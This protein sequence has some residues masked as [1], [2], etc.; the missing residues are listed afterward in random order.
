MTGDI[1]AAADAADSVGPTTTDGCSA[2]TN[3]SAVAGKWALVDRGPL[4]GN[5]TFVLKAQ[6]AQAAGAI[7]VIIA[8]NRKDTCFPPGMSGSDASITI[9]VI[10]I[11]Q[12]DG[13]AIRAQVGNG[14]NATLH[15]DPTELAGVTTEGFV[16]LYAPCTVAAGSSIYHFDTTATPNLL[17][18][19]FISDDLT[20]A[21]DLTIDELREIGWPI[22]Q[23]TGRTILKRR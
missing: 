16:K 5:C 17:M 12:D 9:P 1:V 4:N 14:V 23:P 18:E 21:V 6:N 13:A 7:G 10:S 20:H 15:V 11:T 19:P 2:F 8:D 22:T 3:A